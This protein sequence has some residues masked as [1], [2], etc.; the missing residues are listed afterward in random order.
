MKLVVFSGK[1]TLISGSEKIYF[2][3]FVFQD[4]H[5]NTIKIFHTIFK[6]K[7]FSEDG[8]DKALSPD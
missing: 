4:L 3:V 1:R 6:L 5:S 7:K 2:V 8:I